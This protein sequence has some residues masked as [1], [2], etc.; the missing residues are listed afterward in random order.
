[1][2]RNRSAVMTTPTRPGIAKLNPPC[3]SPR[4]P[5]RGFGAG[6]GPGR[7]R[8]TPPIRAREA[9]SIPMDHRQNNNIDK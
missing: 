5:P 9:D 6:Q 3:A 1:M 4:A 8:A 2:R 7:P